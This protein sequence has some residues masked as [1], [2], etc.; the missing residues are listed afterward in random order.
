MMPGPIGRRVPQR[1]L[2]APGRLAFGIA[3]ALATTLA[4]AQSPPAGAEKGFPAR[5][6]R[7][8]LPFSAGSGPDVFV[9]V[10]AEKLSRTWGQQVTVDARPGANGFIALDEVHFTFFCDPKLVAAY[11]A[12]GDDPEKMAL[13]SAD[14]IKRRIDKAARYV[15]LDQL[16][17]SPQCGFACMVEGN[18][19]SEEEQWAKLALIAK[20]AEDVWGSAA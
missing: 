13:E 1:A 8:T 14:A 16:A 18:L 3:A 15:P 12:R 19:L 7:I 17:L 20:V 11:G 10:L 4:A 9:R 2:V 6:V 5:A